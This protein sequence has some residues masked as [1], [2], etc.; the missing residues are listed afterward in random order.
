MEFLCSQKLRNHPSSLGTQTTATSENCTLD[1]SSSELPTTG[2]LEEALGDEAHRHEDDYRDLLHR[3]WDDME[4]Y[5]EASDSDHGGFP[6]DVRCKPQL[7]GVNLSL[8]DHLLTGFEYSYDNPIYFENLDKHTPDL[9]FDEIGYAENIDALEAD[10]KE[11]DNLLKEVDV[12]FTK[13]ETEG[14]FD[15]TQLSRLRQVVEDHLRAF[16]TKS[17]PARMSYLEPITCQLKSDAE[18][19]TQP[20]WLGREQMEFLR[21]RINNMLSRG[22][23]RPTPNPHYG[24]QA[25][26]VPKKGPDKYRMVVD[27]RKLNQQTRKTSLINA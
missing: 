26:L 17:S 2:Y 19:L 9:E 10:Q 15:T 5:G 3:A 25:F 6:D 1:A 24:S 12:Q 14:N 7:D 20:R 11:Q 23:I 4:L 21:T 13:L 22:L 8:D 18:I 16:G 27:M